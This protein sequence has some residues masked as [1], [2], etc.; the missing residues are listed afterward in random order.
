VTFLDKSEGHTG[1][2]LTIFTETGQKVTMKPAH[3]IF[4]FE[5][6][7]TSKTLFTRKAVYASAIKPG[8]YI[9]TQASGAYI[10]SANRVVGVALGRERGAYAPVTSEGTLFVDGVLVSC[11]ADLADHKLA[12]SLMRPLRA[13]YGLAPNALGAAGHHVHT[14]LRAIIRPVGLR[15][16][17]EE[18]FYK[19][20]FQNKHSKAKMIAD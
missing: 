5:M 3:L 19:G 2:Y 13:I 4:R 14:Y 8:D 6:D 17:G 1:Q 16:L 12:H 20:L 15:I 7:V 9:Y 18:R 11:F 10:A